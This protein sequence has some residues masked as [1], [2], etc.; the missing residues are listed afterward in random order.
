MSVIQGTTIISVTTVCKSHYCLH[1]FYSAPQLS[2]E[3]CRMSGIQGMIISIIE[4]S[5]LL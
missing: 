3:N 1:N 4:I 2:S 5:I